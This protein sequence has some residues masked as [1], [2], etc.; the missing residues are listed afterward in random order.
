MASKQTILV[1]GATGF[2][3]SRTVERLVQ[4]YP[5]HTVIAAGRTIK[6]HAYI[7]HPR[8]HYQLGDLADPAYVAAI[9]QRQPIQ[10]V[11]NCAALSS[12]WGRDEDFYRA[13]V[14]SQQHLIEQAQQT[15]VNRFVFIS[16][17]SLYF[18]YRDRLNIRESDP[19]P[20][21]FVNAYA[22]TKREAEILL[23]QSG[24]SYIALR[25]RALIGRGDTVIMPRLIRAYEEGRLKIIGSGQNRVD[26]T[27]V[28]NV[29]DAILLGLEAPE[30]ACGRPYNITQAEPVLLWPHIHSVLTQLGFEPSAQKVPF[31]LVHTVAGLMELY[32]KSLGGG[33]EPTLTRYSVGTLAR[34]FHMDI[35]QAQTRLDY[36]PRQS[37]AE[38]IT[39]FVTWYQSLEYD[40]N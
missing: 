1:T 8:V 7:D 21:K 39:E 34:H 32:A 11:V 3:G 13:N 27:P 6:A 28:S 20:P 12:P 24:L 10:A 26:L 35:T 2:L 15:G 33:K 40:A 38:A 9:F 22:R 37:V 19:L 31:W 25:P 23:E 30:S 17:P 5:Q 4:A 18:N 14:R 29:V 16:T 36:Q